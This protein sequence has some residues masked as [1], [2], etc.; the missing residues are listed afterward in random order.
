MVEEPDSGS[1][2]TA[3]AG[4]DYVLRWQHRSGIRIG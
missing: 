2:F 3:A 1:L 4:S